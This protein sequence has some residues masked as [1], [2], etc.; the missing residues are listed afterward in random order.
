MGKESFKNLYSI[1]SALSNK[2]ITLLD[3]ITNVLISSESEVVSEEAEKLLELMDSYKEPT[4]PF[5]EIT[6]KQIDQQFENFE[7][8]YGFV[9]WSN[10]LAGS[11]EDCARMVNDDPDYFLGM[12]EEDVRTM[13]IESNEEDREILIDEFN[14]MNINGILI[15]GTI[16][17]WCGSQPVFM[18]RRHLSEI[19][20]ALSGDTCTLYIKDG[21]LR[22][23]CYHH[24]GENHYTIYTFKKGFG[25]DEFEYESKEKMLEQT[26][27]LVPVLDKSFGWGITEEG[28]VNL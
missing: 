24:D 3:A 14:A 16:G 10:V 6:Q 2:D 26:E 20:R 18:I 22:A 21:Q 7:K 17:R 9:I 25:P 8:S 4:V 1:I 27:S 28:K 12:T 5:T 11:D 15:T 23:K 19:F 13:S